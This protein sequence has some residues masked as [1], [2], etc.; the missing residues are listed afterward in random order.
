MELVLAILALG[1]GVGYAR[2]GRLGH[3]ESAP[4][5]FLPLAILGFLVR[6]AAETPSFVAS[7]P[8]ARIGATP[9]ELNVAGF[10]FVL[11]FCLANLRLPGMRAAS[12][13]TLLNMITLSLNGGR[14]PFQLSVA[15]RVGSAARM[16]AAARDGAPHLPDSFHAPL[17]FFGDLIPAPGLTMTKLIS[18]GDVILFVSIAY[19]L[20]ELMVNRPAERGGTD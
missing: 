10:F 4:I 1:V 6:F 11:A 20:E 15:R 14:M 7:G 3:L 19:M 12:I 8:L 18:V 9:A 2:G 13:G 16:V 17:W 5:R